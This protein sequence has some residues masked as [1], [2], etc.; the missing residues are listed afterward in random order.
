MFF[1]SIILIFGFLRDKKSRSIVNF[2]QLVAAVKR[3]FEVEGYT[4]LPYYAEHHTTRKVAEVYRVAS[5]VVAPHGAGLSNI[6]FSPPHIPIIELAYGRKGSNCAESNRPWFI[7]KASVFSMTHYT[8]I[9]T[10][11]E[12]PIFSKPFTAPISK[13]VLTLSHALLE[14]KRLPNT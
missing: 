4:V 9:D 3:S 8:V 2:E 1:P 11:S 6:I 14:R 12:C 13:I 10:S 5:A 7:D